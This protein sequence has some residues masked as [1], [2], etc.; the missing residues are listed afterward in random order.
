MTRAGTYRYAVNAD[1]HVVLQASELG[2]ICVLGERVLQ[3]HGKESIHVAVEGITVSQGTGN[4]TE[5]GTD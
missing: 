1:I 2:I 4:R 5:G 3:E